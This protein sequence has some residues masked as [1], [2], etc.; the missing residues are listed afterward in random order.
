MSTSARS[1]DRITIAA[2]CNTDWDAMAGNDQ[3]RFCEHCQLQVTNLSTL[4]RSEAMRLVERSQG[5][6]CVR[7][8]QRANGEVLTGQLPRRLH[9]IGRRVSRLAAGAFSA[10]LS[11][12]SA[13]AQETS[14]RNET[15]PRQPAAISSVMPAGEGAHISGVVK[16][17]NGAV[18]RNATVTLTNLKEHS[19]FVFVTQDDGAY[20][21]SLLNAGAYDLSA[22]AAGFSTQNQKLNVS[23][24]TNNTLEIELGLPIIMA[25]VEVIAA[26]LV[27]TS[28]QGSV[29]ISEPSEP[30]VKAAFKNDLE[31][32]KQ[33]IPVTEDVNKLDGSTDTTALSYAIEKGNGE[34]VDLLL[35]VGAIP[36]TSNKY[37]MRPLMYLNESAS[38][39]LLH[40]LL[41]AGADVNA[42]DQ[43]NMSVLNHAVR[44]STPAVIKELIAAGARL[45]VKDDRGNT[46]VMNAAWN[47]DPSVVRMLVAAG[48][49]VRARNEDGECAMSLAAHDRNSETLKAIID[50]GGAL[51][52]SQEQLDEM[53]LTAAVDDDPQVV[54]ILIEKAGANP[55]AKDE[56]GGTA[57][58]EAADNGK[59]ETLKVLIEAGADLNATDKDGCTA[60]MKADDIDKVLMLLDAGADVTRKNSDGKTALALATD[61]E[62]IK[63]L[64]SR[65]APE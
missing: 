57:M 17:P 35:S 40:Q 64:K 43:A 54:K 58:M 47:A 42:R 25:V 62:I 5:R 26:P 28:Y 51:T 48:A 37:G 13:A 20:L 52:L 55:N 41:A 36:N 8:V 12:A 9:H 15:V 11:V 16:D 19:S 23:A 56:D 65:G 29:G 33:L 31:A 3:V 30:L 7:Y 27:E 34:M 38:V 59:P 14:G 10:T 32:A 45:D 4:T 46:V 50:A 18:V 44:E 49:D 2:P 61:N 39:E 22:E 53:L 6:L 1:F 21:F 60:L 63:L 24:A